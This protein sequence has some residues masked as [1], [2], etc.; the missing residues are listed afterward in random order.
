MEAISPLDF[1]R[2]K[3]G[4]NS[5]E[6]HGNDVENDVE[7]RQNKPKTRAEIA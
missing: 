3:Y 4:Q 5:R 6:R 7:T 1:C 2:P